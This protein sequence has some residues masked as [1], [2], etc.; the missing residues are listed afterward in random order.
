MRNVTLITATATAARV[1]V[2]DDEPSMLV[3]AREVLGAAGNRVLTAESPD[4]ALA[5]LGETPIDLVIT[6]IRLPGHRSG[7]D[8]LQELRELDSSIPV[9]VVTGYDSETSVRVALDRGAAGYLEKPFTV[10]QLISKVEETLRQ[11]TMAEAQVRER[12]VKPTIATALA[13]AIEVRQAD[14]EEHVERM[15]EIALT[16]GRRLRLSRHDLESL[17][18]GA[19]LHDVGKIGIPDAILLKPA[20]LSREERE[21]MKA[22][23]VIGDQMLRHLDLDEI[24]PI[25]RHHH[26]RWDGTGYPDK[27]AGDRIP[28]LARIVAVADSVEAMA[29][30]RP[31]RAALSAAQVRAELAHGRGRQWDPHIV[32]I[33]LDLIDDETIVFETNGAQISSYAPVRR[34]MQ[35]RTHLP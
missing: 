21:L 13:N 6:D 10:N 30:H 33:A 9:V 2:V 12:L 31:Y 18:L 22:H 7:L 15:A 25:V 23:T 11:K 34:V 27:L 26:E 1:L 24:R 5:V 29:A 17:E 19:I 3:I 16:I 8:L 28:L 35:R 14:L 32:D 4:E 20:V